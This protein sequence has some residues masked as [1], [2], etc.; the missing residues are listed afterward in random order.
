[1]RAVCEL[2]SDV[3]HGLPGGVSGYDGNDSNR[4]RKLCNLQLHASRV[5]TSPRIEKDTNVYGINCEELSPE[6]H[7]P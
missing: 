5:S 7:R 6:S 1:M 4:M 3:P 2:P